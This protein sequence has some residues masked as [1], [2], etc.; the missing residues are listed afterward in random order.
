MKNFT[1]HY[2]S[3]QMSKCFRNDSYI[4][5][6]NTYLFIRLHNGMLVKIKFITVIRYKCITERHHVEVPVCHNQTPM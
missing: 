3:E 1:L 5:F 6:E 2:V 4:Y